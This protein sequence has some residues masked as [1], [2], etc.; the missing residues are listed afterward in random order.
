MD[1]KKKCFQLIFY[2]QVMRPSHSRTSQAQTQQSEAPMI[3]CR[4]R[5][6]KYNYRQEF[7]L[8]TGQDVKG[9]EAVIESSGYLGATGE[10]LRG[11]AARLGGR[12]EGGEGREPGEG[13]RGAC[14]QR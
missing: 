10:H 1:L 14:S 8:H 2:S 6:I 13:A 3:S 9:G 7:Y 12:G 11:G 5:N 4:F